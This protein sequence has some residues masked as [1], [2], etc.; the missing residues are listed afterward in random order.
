MSSSASLV[1]GRQSYPLCA[2]T[3]I[4]SVKLA[5]ACELA[6]LGYEHKGLFLDLCACRFFMKA[7]RKCKDDEVRGE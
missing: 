2:Q 5:V 4:P 3:I 1:A 7:V 6:G